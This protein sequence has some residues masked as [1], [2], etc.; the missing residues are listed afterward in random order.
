[1]LLILILDLD[2]NLRFKINSISYT[3]ALR[4]KHSKRLA[5]TVFVVKSIT[6]FIIINNDN[7]SYKRI[8]LIYCLTMMTSQLNIV[9]PVSCLLIQLST[10]L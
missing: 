1:V 10:K 6:R 5:K 4:Y 8:P 3:Y 2:K 9:L 7:D